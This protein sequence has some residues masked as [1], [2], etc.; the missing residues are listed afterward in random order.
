MTGVSPNQ[1]PCWLTYD[2]RAIAR[3]LPD[4]VG[5][6]LGTGVRIGEAIAIQW[7]DVDLDAG[8]IAVTASIVRINGKGLIRQ[9]EES[10]KL[11]ARRLDAPAGL[12]A[13]LRA[14]HQRLHPDPTDPVFPAVRGGWRDPSNTGAD[15]RD[16]FTWA[17]YPG[18]TF[19]LIG[20]KTGASRFDASGQSARAAA[21]QLG[22]PR[23]S[24]NQDRYYGRQAGTNAADVL[25]AFFDDL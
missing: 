6:L 23:P 1:R 22:H 4:L 11:T 14:R 3:D 24:M 19:H 9:V 20:R 7:R 2:D 10:S 8:T 15:P 17:G 25:A 18:L 21:D 16:F 12:I 13:I 5:F